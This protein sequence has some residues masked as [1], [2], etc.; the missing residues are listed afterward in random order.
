MK[1]YRSGTWDEI[2]SSLRTDTLAQS[3]LFSGPRYSGRLSLALDL[4]KAMGAEDVIFIPER[5]L[6]LGIMASYNLLNEKYSAR[7]LSY[8]ISEVRLLL[9][10][11]HPSLQSRGAEGGKDR[12]FSQAA[13][14]S[15]MV[16]DLSLL[17]VDEERQ[18]I[19]KLAGDIYKLSLKSDILF[20][21][22]KK[23]VISVDDV[24]SIQNYLVRKKDRSMV[25]IENIEDSTEASRNA[26]LKVLEE[27]YKDTYFVL[28][29]ANSLR[30]LTTILSRLRKYSF[31]PLPRKDLN[32]YLK[33]NFLTER[34]YDSYGDFLFEMSSTAAEREIILSNAS[35]MADALINKKR[36]DVDDLDEVYSSLE[37]NPSYFISL[38]IKEVKSEFLSGSLCARKAFSLLKGLDDAALSNAVYNQNIKSAFDLA[39]REASFVS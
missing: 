36:L 4:A 10:Q 5:D 28:I 19:L 22:K 30:I 2:Y 3:L 34:D 27:P 7:F 11:Y 23:G 17:D 18:K 24:R 15:D 14:I 12:I 8:F 29:S 1:L 31:S 13:D 39:L 26:M 33:N 16:Y 38:V 25:I 9:M 21:G 37:G 20:R 6:S 35:K 32:I